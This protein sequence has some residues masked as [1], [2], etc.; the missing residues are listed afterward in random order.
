MLCGQRSGG[1]S[2]LPVIGKELPCY[3]RGHVGRRLVEEP[4]IDE[5]HGPL[6]GAA[7]G[8]DRLSHAERRQ[9]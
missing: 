8:R 5:G 3:P 6:C 9:L 7:C 1:S 2:F 4:G